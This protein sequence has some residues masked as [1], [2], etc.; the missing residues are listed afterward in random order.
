MKK[1]KKFKYID[2]LEGKVVLDTCEFEYNKGEKPII[3]KW[4]DFE[5][6]EILKIKEKQKQIF[7]DNVNELLKN[8]QDDFLKRLEKSM[9]KEDLLNDFLKQCF[10]IMFAPI[11]NYEIITLKEWNCTFTLEELFEIQ[12]YIKDVVKNGKSYGYDFVHSPNCVNQNKLKIHSYIY[13]QTI[14]E[15]YVWLK[16]LTESN[17]SPF[18][19]LEENKDVPNNQTD[20]ILEN[21]EVSKPN[22][23]PNI[24]VGTNDIAYLLFSAWHQ[25]F[26]NKKSVEANYSFI[27]RKMIE[28]NLILRLKH[29][30]YILFLRTFDID[31]EKVRN[32]SDCS[33]TIKTELYNDLKTA[34]VK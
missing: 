24:F 20:N 33:T 13:A 34:I 18:Y 31:I 3:V 30:E 16:H 32:I 11:P 26:I 25:R 17:N 9:M 29:E 10:D 27:I 5:E 15:Y 2:W 4:D 19:S 22:P 6:N 21:K 8:F 14:A 7:E 12:R 23:Y 1:V 28:D